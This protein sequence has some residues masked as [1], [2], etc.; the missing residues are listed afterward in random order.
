MFVSAV[1]QSESAVCIHISPFF[2]FPAH[3]GHHSALSRIP[4]AMHRF[5]LVIY[6]T[7]VWV[8]WV[9]CAQVLSHIWLF[10]T[11]W[12]IA[13]QSSL[14]MGLS[15]QEYWGGLPFPPPG[16]LR[17]PRIEPG[18]PAAPALAGGFLHHLNHHPPGDLPDSEIK[19]MSPELAGG[20]FTISATWEAHGCCCCCCC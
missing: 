10:A 16:Y 8:G 14:S 9:M 20:F 17:N 18:S 6:F 7:H 15:Q 13:H 5:S 2:G 4:S 11:P 19:T 3:L 12:T 1:Q